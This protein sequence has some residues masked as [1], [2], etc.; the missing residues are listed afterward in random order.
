MNIQLKNAF[1]P[2]NTQVKC[3]QILE[4][5]MIVI[6]EQMDKTDNNED[7]LQLMQYKW[8]LEGIIASRT[9]NRFKTTK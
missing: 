8:E 4:I 2:I 6:Q 1:A 3:T 5:E 7:W 9:Q